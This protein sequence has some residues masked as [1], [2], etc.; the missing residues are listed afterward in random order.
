[1]PQY[2]PDAAEEFADPYP[3]Y[4]RLLADDPAQSEVFGGWIVSRY[5]DVSA[6]LRDHRFT[7]KNLTAA[8][9]RNLPPGHEELVNA[10]IDRNSLSVAAHHPP[11]HTRKRALIS[12]R[13]LRNRVEPLAGSVQEVVDRLLE[14]VMARGYMDVIGDF[15]GPLPLVIISRLVGVPDSDGP[16]MEAVADEAIELSGRAQA[17]IASVQALLHSLETFSTYAEGLIE[18]HRRFPQDDL[19]SDLLSQ[20]HAGDGFGDAELIANA[21]MLVGAGHETTTKLIG[22]AL[23]ALLRHPTELRR[24]ID[25]PAMIETAI[26]ELLRFD[27][28]VQTTVRLAQED[29]ELAGRPICAGDIL[30]FVLGA[31]NRDAEQFPEPDR[32]DLARTPNRHLGFG[33]GTHACLGAHVARLEMRIA[34][35][36]VIRRLKEIRLVDRGVAWDHNLTFRGPKKLLLEF[37]PAST[38]D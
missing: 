6:G 10:V 24:L 3:G 11:E 23:L 1:M 19:I 28:V 15:A 37:R 31:A 16:L 32:L 35:Q 26:D 38:V 2:I 22:T 30:T 14:K 5:R 8:R 4:R 29:V 7:T 21:G 33:M 18:S 20:Q 27:A 34:I 13:F 17:D 12:P 9:L 25:H 36:T